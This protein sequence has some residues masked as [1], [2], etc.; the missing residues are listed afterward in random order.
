MATAIASSI[1]NVIARAYSTIATVLP[2]AMNPTPWVYDLLAGGS[3]EVGHLGFGVGL[4]SSRP[5]DDRGKQRAAAFLNAESEIGVR[6]Q[7]RLRAGG[8]PTD[9][10]T[11]LTISDLVVAALISAA[12]GSGGGQGPQK[13]RWLETRARVVADGTHLL[14]EQRYRVWHVST[15]S[16]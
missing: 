9:Y 16:L 14:I 8:M 4:L 13:W 15:L 1:G 5:Q 11:A 3:R 6:V 12:D 7:Y 2:G 10:Q